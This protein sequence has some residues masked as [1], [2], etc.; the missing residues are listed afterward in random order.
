MKTKAET[1]RPKRRLWKVSVMLADRPPLVKGS[2]KQAK[3]LTKKEL[4]DALQVK[5]GY[6][7]VTPSV[8]YA[9]VVIN[10]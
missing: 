2:K 9:E 1:D 10:N 6:G 7:C 5:T 3:F 4:L 8:V